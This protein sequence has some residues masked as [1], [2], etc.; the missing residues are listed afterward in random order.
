MNIFLLYPD[1]ITYGQDSIAN[2]FSDGSPLVD[3]AKRVFYEDPDSQL[4]FME[5]L[6]VVKRKGGFFCVEGNRRLYILKYLQSIDM[7]FCDVP[8]VTYHGQYKPITARDGVPLHVRGGGNVI[9]ELD[10]MAYSEEAER[11][12]TEYLGFGMRSDDDDD[13]EDGDDDDYDDAEDDDDDDDD[14]VGDDDDEDYD[15]GCYYDDDYYDDDYYYEDDD[16][17][18]D[19]EGED[20]N[21]DDNGDDDVDN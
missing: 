16:Y 8:V 12:V 5:P 13:D 20:D 14:D 3:F 4:D 19:D 18:G 2:H 11:Y 9:Q 7:L 21:K 10:D 6:E 1:D 15:G 17:Y